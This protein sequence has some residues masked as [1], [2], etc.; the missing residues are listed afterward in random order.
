MC[1]SE[2]SRYTMCL[3]HLP[4]YNEDTQQTFYRFQ[5]VFRSGKDLERDSDRQNEPINSRVNPRGGHQPRMS[6]T[7]REPDRLGPFMQAL[8]SPKSS[9]TGC[10]AIDQRSASAPD[11]D[12][13]WTTTLVWKSFEIQEQEKFAKLRLDHQRQHFGVQDPPSIPSTFAAFINNR[14]DSLENEIKALKSAIE[15]KERQ[16][17]IREMTGTKIMPAFGGKNLGRAT[18][19]LAQAIRPVTVWDRTGAKEL[20]CDAEFVATAEYRIGASLLQEL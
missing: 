12:G 20:Y 19:L 18:E 17:A 16:L 6:D 3:V 4:L 1:L 7:D 9:E 2:D 10:D 8:S 14:L 13:L 11:R 15:G 5:P